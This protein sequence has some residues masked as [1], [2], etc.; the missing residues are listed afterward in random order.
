[1]IAIGD[2]HGCLETFNTLLDRIS[3]TK[4]DTIF[5]LGDLVNKG[6]NSIGVV[7]RVIDLMLHKYSI[8][9]LRGNHESFVIEDLDAHKHLIFYPDGEALPNTELKHSLDVYKRFFNYLPYYYKVGKTILVH[10]GINFKAESPFEDY[11]SMM[12]I[13]DYYLV[14]TSGWT[15]IHGHDPTHLKFIEDFLKDGSKALNIDNGCYKQ[16]KWG[17]GNLIALDIKTKNM[18][19]Q[20]NIEK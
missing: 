18:T 16:D 5:L 7:D 11:E 9:P 10:A 6:P 2:I 4:N 15:V 1:M 19:L 13:R 20:P 12:W 3:I 8:Y 14:E 17:M